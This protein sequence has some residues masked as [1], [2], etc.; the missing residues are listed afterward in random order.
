MS[1]FT[2]ELRIAQKGEIKTVRQEAVR[3]LGYKNANPDD[4][5]EKLIS[6]CEKELLQVI[7]GRACYAHTNVKFPSENVVDLGFGEILSKS[8]HKHL[9]GCH[10]AILMAATIGIGTDRLTAKYS[11]IKPAK[12]LIIDALGS[13]AVEYWCDVVEQELTKN[14]KLHCSRFS[15]GYG[16]FSLEHQKDFA[17]WLDISRKLGVTLSDTL[18][19]TPAKS[20]TAVIGLGKNTRTCGNKCQICTNQNCIYRD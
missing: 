18:L 12:S 14:E 16:D 20:V 6:E 1:D 17:R 2:V 15:A 3:Y 4:I 7:S 9:Y 10:S 5:T 19:M 8:L 11:R 13:S